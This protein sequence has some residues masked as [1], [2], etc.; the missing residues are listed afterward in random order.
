MAGTDDFNAAEVARKEFAT[1][2]RGFDQYEVR[3]YL[4]KVAAEMGM[5]QERDRGMRERLAELERKRPSERALADEEIEAALGIEATKV[6]HAAREAASEI[7]ARAEEN[8][9]R[10]LRE[11]QDEAQ[12]MR[13]EAASVLGARTEEAE[14][15]ASQ[16][17]EA[18]QQRGR[19][20]VAEAQAVR[21]RMLRDLARRRRHAEAQVQLLI[22]GRERLVEALQSAVEATGATTSQL[23]SIELD[24]LP[25]SEPGN[26]AEAAATAPAA[27][28][29]TGPPP[30]PVATAVVAAVR[31]V[32]DP[33]EGPEPEAVPEPRGPQAGSSAARP[34][35][36]ARRGGS[37][38]RGRRRGE[39]PV[40]LVDDEVEG[41]RIIRPEPAPAAVEEPEP[42]GSTPTEAETDPG[43]SAP[44]ADVADVDEAQGAAEADPASEAPPSDGAPAESEAVPGD[45]TSPESPGDDLSPPDAADAEAASSDAVPAETTSSASAE[46]AIAEEGEGVP[47]LA[48]PVVELF[49]RLR[50]DRANPPA[51]EAT[52]QTEPVAATADEADATGR[53]EAPPAAETDEATA[54]DATELDA[55]FEARDAAVEDSERA[56]ARSLKRALS[57]EQNEVL[58]SL[59]R[60]KGTPRIEVLLPDPD[61][62]LA[63][64]ERVAA[65]PLATAATAG[66]NAGDRSAVVDI[67]AMADAVA[68]DDLARGFA[69][70]V[71]TDLRAR[72]ER[73]LDAGTTD[74][75][76][77]VEAISAGYREW[78]SARSEPAARHHAVAAYAAGAYAVAPAGQLRWLVDRAEGGCPDCDD[79][80]LAGPTPKGSPYPTGQLHPPAH[81]GCR[82]L[83][84]PLA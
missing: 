66:A 14:A 39:A 29:E 83:L 64:Y 19:E 30:G 38:R 6:I 7:R 27:S 58:D 80:A 37:P 50:A 56:L 10:L 18:A 54:G 74:S 77:L 33:V 84:V 31:P 82:C 60:L 9:A 75:E 20:M 21:E 43:P 3:A 62:H 55:R 76:A 45:V 17:V 61:V 48:T 36:E 52:S 15:T 35:L 67:A 23:A 68:V 4:A 13:T 59:R 40:V 32:A 81:T 42:T 1:G 71:A 73:A 70:E 11:A 12:T 26:E 65:G 53:E 25:V 8:V 24:D 46:E 28:E 63:R 57:D 44:E 78:K 79:N 22:G 41:V 16:I 5:L 49:A 2:F 51:D 69:D 47:R 72:L 34:D